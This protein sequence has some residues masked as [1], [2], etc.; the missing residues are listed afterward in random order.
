[1]QYG[2]FD[3]ENHEYVIDRVDL[4]TSWTNYIGVKDMCAVLNH[5]AGGYIFYKSPEYH[6]IT[7]FRPNGVPM[8]RPGHYVYLRDDESKD[9]WSISWQPVGKPLDQAKYTCRHGMSYSVYECDY[10]KIRASQ[11]MSIAMD[12]PVE[13]WDVRIKN[14]DDRPRAISVFSYLEFSFH[15]IEM[16]NKNFQMSMYA[17]GSSYDK[18]II[19]CDLFYEEFGY[20]FFTANFEPDSYD[21]LRDKFLGLY[22]TEDNP[23][24]VERGSLSNSSELGNNHCGALHK[25]FTLAPGEEIRVIFLLGEGNREEGVRIRGKYADTEMVDQV[26]RQLEHYWREKQAKLQIQT[27]N[28]GMNTLINTWTLYQAEVNIMFSRFAS[29]IEVGGRTGLGYRDT[30]QDSMTVIHSNPEKCRQRIVELLRG[31]VKQGY[32]LHL[33]Q[34]EWFDPNEKNKKPFKSPTVVPTPKLSDMIHGLEDTCS[35]DALWLV[36]SINEY[37]KETGEFSFLD[38]IYTYADGGKGSVYEHMKRILD[39]SAEQVGADGICKGLR[40][41]WNDCLNL[42]GGE[43]A[44]VSFLHYWA[45]GKFLELAEYRGEAEDVETYTAMAERVKKACDQVLWDEKWYIRGITKNGRKIGTSRDK[46]GKI[47]L[48]SNAWA[49]LSGAAPYEKGILAMDSVYEELFTEY[50]IMLNGPAYTEP[51]EDIGFVTR[52]YPGLK[53]NASVFSHPNPW[54]WAAECRLGRG[55]RAMEFYNALCPYYQND[56]IEIREAEPYSYC[57]FIMGKDHTAFGRARHPF[58]TGT[59]G[60][61]YFS[62]THYMLGVRPGLDTLTI[63]PCIPK[64]WDGFS[65]KRQWRGAD[66]AIEVENPKHVSKGVQT[67]Y[68]DGKEVK[69]IPA[70]VRGSSHKVKVIMG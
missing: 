21:C 31:L 45:I 24:G 9:Y 54:A 22:H 47:H 2:H 17:A 46:E 20:Q 34:P 18:G 11:K 41:D 39:F 59:G 42:G 52:V 26:Y 23:V 15:Q 13:I 51:D 67:L 29:F 50:G 35:D 48:E 56:K 57:Q 68:L 6:R 61:A 69:E 8:D 63:D 60:W 10:S 5:T 27:P 28:Q 40:A 70:D 55:D 32:G 66:Y 12:D 64:E 37:V 14:E 53:E 36:A 16:D 1:M 43:S 4:P 65:M 33:F 58:M 38:E 44:M 49:V 19:E 7:R 3:N 62:A 25:R 30:S